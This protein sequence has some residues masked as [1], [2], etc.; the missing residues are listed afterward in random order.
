MPYFG[1]PKSFYPFE[2]S[3]NYLIAVSLLEVVW[4][5]MRVYDVGTQFW[6]HVNSCL[7]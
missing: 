2:V 7:S 5:E 1:G 6:I 3:V 4:R